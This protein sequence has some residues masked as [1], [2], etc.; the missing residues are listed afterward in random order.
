MARITYCCYVK[1]HE[2]A[3]E[4]HAP[5][6]GSNRSFGV[7]FAIVFLAL[8]LYPLLKGRLPTSPLSITSLG[9]SA[10]F[11]AISFLVPRLLAIPNLLWFKLGLKLHV[12]FSFAIMAFLFFGLFLPIGLILKLLGKTPIPNTEK[13][14]KPTYWVTREQSQGQSSGQS[15][16]QWTDFKF[17]F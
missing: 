3:S 15:D 4:M 1:H 13:S 10:T 16:D 5:Q 7:V 12:V 14:N 6:L 11:L 17:Q 8:G 9:L 2:S